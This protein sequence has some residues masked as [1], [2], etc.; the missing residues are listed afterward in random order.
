MLVEEEEEVN[1]GL[2]HIISTSD[3][4]R[5]CVFVR[6]VALIGVLPVVYSSVLAIHAYV[7]NTSPGYPIIRSGRFST[8]IL[9]HQQPDYTGYSYKLFSVTLDLTTAYHYTNYM[10]RVLV[11]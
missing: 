6:K 8:Q 1:A 10:V 2:C 9:Q 4:V 5:P 3:Q 7:W 11:D